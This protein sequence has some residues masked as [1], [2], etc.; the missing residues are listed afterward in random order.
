MSRRYREYNFVGGCV[1]GILTAL[2]SATGDVYP[3]PHLRLSLGNVYNESFIDIWDN[4]KLL[5]LMRDRDNLKGRCKTCEFRN[6][7]GGCRAAAFRVFGDV[8][9]EDPYCF[10]ELL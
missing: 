7:C 3:C 9:A 1:A 5:N 6:I 2:V 10:K 4:N 8:F